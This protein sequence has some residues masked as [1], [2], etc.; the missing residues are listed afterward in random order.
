MLSGGVVESGFKQKVA[1][2]IHKHLKNENVNETQH[3]DIKMI[4]NITVHN[5]LTFKVLL[6]LQEESWC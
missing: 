2:Q 3:F 5:L 1:D 4:T 6:N